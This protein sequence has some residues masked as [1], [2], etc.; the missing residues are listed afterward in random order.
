MSRH[1]ALSGRLSQVVE[2]LPDRRTVLQGLGAG[3]GAAALS[4][5]LASLN[6]AAAAAT[7]GTVP[8]D[9]SA[10]D[11]TFVAAYAASPPAVDEV[12]FTMEVENLMAL[13]YGGDFMQYKPVPGPSE[14]VC[15]SDMAA[16]G[17]A[18][19]IGRWVDRWEGSPDYK[20]WTFHIRPGIKSWAGNEMTS[21]DIRWSWERAF[22]MKGVR[23]FFAK[24]MFLDKPSDIDVVDQY[25]VRFN[26]QKPSPVILKLMAMSYYGGPF[27]SKEARK[28]ATASDPWAKDWLKNNDAGFGPYHIVKSIPGQEMELTRNENYQPKPPIKRILIRIVPDPATRMALLERGAVDYAMRLPERSLQALAKNPGVQ[29]VR[30]RANFI[31]YVGPVETNEIM[32]KTKVRQAMAYATPYDEIREK[33]YFNQGNLIKSITPAIFPN[34]TD[35]FWVYKLD[36]AKAKALLAEAGYPGGFDLKL[37]FD[38]SIAEMAEAAVL[39]KAAYDAVGIR[40]TLDPLPAAVYSERKVKRQL[41]CQ[42]D[43]FQWPWVADTGYTGWVYLGNPETTVNNSVY[44]N[45]PEFNQLVTEM[46]QMPPGPERDKKDLRVQELAAQEVPW[47]FL[48][49]PGWR[50]AMKKGWANFHWYPDNN[51]HYEWLY[52]S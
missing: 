19:V 17:N 3:L 8:S 26:L 28:H 38:N 39:I 33:V 21:E 27:D 31:P 23:Y 11:Y 22:E 48:V 16:A 40:T 49:E 51:V 2:T 37:S 14:I 44:F 15:V 10:M 42:V 43:N 25:T 5:F 34:Y 24:A 52:K 12:A 1:D 4:P 36:P 9:K 32:A 6:A 7:C 46:M 29:I 18:G 50:E 13:T 20:T 30:A 35:R 41:M 47:I 45:H